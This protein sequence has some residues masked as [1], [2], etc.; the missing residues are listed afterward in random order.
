M[1]FFAMPA[2]ALSLLACMHACI[3]IKNLHRGREHVDTDNSACTRSSR[4]ESRKRP[5]VDMLVGSRSR[6]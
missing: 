3:F 4:H 1:I 2:N 6:E 5:Y